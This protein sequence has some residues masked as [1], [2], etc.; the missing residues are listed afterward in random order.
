M[1]LLDRIYQEVDAWASKADQAERPARRA[2]LSGVF[3]SAAMLVAGLLVVWFGHE[4]R[5][6]E[7]PALASVVR[8]VA[9]GRGVCLL[10][11]GLLVLAAT[12]VLRVL[13]MVSVYLRR[14][15]LFMALV[16][17]VVLGL[18]ALGILLGTG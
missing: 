8:G 5:P 1:T 17:T 2:L 13:A 4:E 14:R 15:E 11:A 16:S 3:L 10:Y 9:A 18:L 7:P 6:N 12:P